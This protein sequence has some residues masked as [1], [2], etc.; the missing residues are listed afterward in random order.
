[1]IRKFTYYFLACLAALSAGSC[2]DGDVSAP[3]RSTFTVDKTVGLTAATEFTFI[4]NKV[5]AKSISLLPYG[6]ENPSFGGVLVESFT[7]GT[8]T[9]KYKYDRAGIFNAVVVTSNLSADG[10]SIKRSYSDPI[11]ITVSSDKKEI[12]A[13]TIDKSTK[14]SLNQDIKII[15][16]TM[17]FGTDKA[18]LKAKYAASPITTVTVGSTV[19]ESEKTVNNFSSPVVYKVTANNGSSSSYTVTVNVTPAETDNAIK[20]F[21]GKAISKSTKDKVLDAY[22]DNTLKNI[23]LLA[24]YGTAAEAKDSLRVSYAM[25]GKFAKLKYGSAELKKDSLLNL[26][27]PKTVSAVAED[28]AANNYA[29]YMTVVPKLSLSLNTLNPTVAGKTEDYSIGLTGLKGTTITTLATT[30]NI[31]LPAGVTVTGIKIG[32]TAFTSGD[33]V[34][35][36]KPVKFTLTVNDTNIGVTYTVVFVATLTIVP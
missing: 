8:A 27:A 2:G 4:V 34:D 32:T 25:T 13:F 33:L 21:S 20:S 15:I 31:D 30:S 16:I 17:P 19:Q 26:T 24:P 28:G 14:D 11:S 7:D 5:E 9:V 12:T 6:V 36:S 22:V 1:M 10:S 18:S 3:P 35:Y 29:L 23:V